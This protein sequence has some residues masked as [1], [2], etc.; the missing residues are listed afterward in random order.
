MPFQQSTR[1]MQ[2]LQRQTGLRLSFQREGERETG[3]RA[4]LVTPGP[5][6][7]RATPHSQTHNKVVDNAMLFD[8]SCAHGFLSTETDVPAKSAL[9]SK[10]RLLRSWSVRGAQ[11]LLHRARSLIL[12]L[13][14]RRSKTE[15]DANS[16]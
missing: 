5:Y 11:E 10:R 3:E 8:T 2:Q 6:T 14:Q 16:T 15:D 1:E 7:V 12:H 13:A 9:M 4:A